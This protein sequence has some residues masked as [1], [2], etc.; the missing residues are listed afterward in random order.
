MKP[1]GMPNQPL[2]AVRM[3]GELRGDG[4]IGSDI[5][6]NISANESYNIQGGGYQL[7]QMR[8]TD[9]SNKSSTR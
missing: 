1:T 3:K 2:R 5:V 6:S 8:N 4:T 9:Y 7:P